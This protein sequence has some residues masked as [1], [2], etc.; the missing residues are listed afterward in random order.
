MCLSGIHYADPIELPAQMIQTK[1]HQPKPSDLLRDSAYKLTQF[2]PAQIQ[3]LEASITM[4][5]VRGK[6]QPHVKCLVRGN[7]I[8]L[9]SEEIVRQL[10]LMVLTQ[11]LGYPVSRIQVE[12]PVQMGGST[13]RADIVIVEQTRPTQP[14]V[15]VEL[16]E[17]NSR[18]GRRQLESYCKA[19]GASIGVWCNGNEIEYFFKQTDPRS[20]T[21]YLEKLSYLPNAQQNLSD[22]L[23]VR[24]TIKQLLQ[25]DKLQDKSL[26]DIVLE[27]EDIVLANAGEDS[28]EEIFK[29]LFAKL[30]DEYKSSANADEIATLL[31]HQATLDTID[32]SNFR[33]LEFRNTGTEA[34]VSNR[35]GRLFDDARNKWP[36]I[37]P[38]VDAFRLTPTH[39][40]TCVSFLQDVKLFNSNLE[41]VD[42]AFEYL[43]NKQ[44]KGDKGQYFTPRYVIDM[45]VKMLNPQA[46]EAM[47]D[48]AAGSCGFP[49]HTIFYVWGQLN[50]HAPNLLTT[51]TRT[52]AEI[53]YVRDKVFAIDF[54]PLSVRV[55]RALNIIAGDGQTN[56]LQLNTLDFTQ[57]DQTTQGAAWQGNFSNGFSKLARYRVERQSNRQFG[58]DILMANP[59]F[60]GE[61]NDP[62][63]IHNHPGVCKKPDGKFQ[64]KVGRDTL[65]IERNLN[66]LKPGGRMAVV[67]PQGK[68]NNSSDKNIREYIAEN[69]RILAVVGLHGNVFKPH[70]S[71]K[72]SVLFVQ[73]WDDELC[74]KVDDYPIFF[75]T[76]R[77]PS[78]DS[79]GEKIYRKDPQGNKL[80]DNHGHF[81][82]QHDLFS[83]NLADGT[84]IPLGITEA[85]IEFAKKERLSF[86]R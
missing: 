73:K 34:E 53:D 66:Y 55:G 33:L 71:V 7:D 46:H 3:A 62:V 42:D 85:F 13:K 39:L 69:C 72:T 27:F 51:Q 56:V 57:W 81:I 8:P 47:I 24:F 43:V 20:N 48:T 41:V 68:F 76:M 32:D 25:E 11:D 54:S 61:I 74:P 78:K 26:K 80:K 14:Y 37:F 75:A 38:S 9:G 22:V 29:L 64:H 40:K 6:P 50:P 15:I 82:V 36:G 65:F 83:T 45:C 79:S 59:P 70:T 12:Y 84:H 49:M 58:F 16:K 5:N 30:Y 35:L 77:E 52:P 19:E 4:K 60:A 21:T 28:F 18:E 23:N 10:Y 63:M 1:P 44:Q 2:K 31:K 86:F 67:L 17:P